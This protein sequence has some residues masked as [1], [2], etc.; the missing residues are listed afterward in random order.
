MNAENYYVE[1]KKGCF[2][3]VKA[4]LIELIKEKA[5]EKADEK[6]QDVFIR[7][8]HPDENWDRTIR[9]EQ[10]SRKL[11]YVLDDLVDIEDFLD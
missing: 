11:Y 3:I 8:M 4:E 6:G 7:P 9:H 2:A 1:N 5:D 10:G